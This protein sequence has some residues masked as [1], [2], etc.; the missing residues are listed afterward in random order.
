M[1]TGS[2][3]AAARRQLSAVEGESP[4]DGVLITDGA[5]RRYLSGFT[6]SAGI[7]LITASAALLLT[8]S[9]YIEQATAQA[10]EFEVIKYEGPP[11]PT[12]AAQAKR[13]SAHRLGFESEEMSVDSYRRLLQA[14]EREAAEVELVPLRGFVEQLRQVKDAGEIELIRQAVEIADR[15]FEQV[16][17]GLRPGTTEREVAW[18]LEVAMRQRGADGLSF[19]IIVAAGPNGAMPHHSPSDRPIQAGEPVVIDMG[20]RY[21]GYCSDMTRTIVLGEAGEQFWHV[22]QTVLQA[23]QACEAG[24]RAGLLGKQADALARDVI[25]AAGHKEH[26]GHGTGHGVGLEIHEAPYLTFTERGEATLP[27][28][29]VVTVE[30][31]IYLSGWGGVRIEDMIVVGQARSQI[32]TTAHKQPIIDLAS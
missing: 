29:C 13:L 14:L 4:L 22:Y 19:P 15:A 20:C 27:E 2:R 3:L 8:D 21:R 17:A 10:R 28:R 25:A 7:L 1:A 32:L 12:V 9:R 31:G 23:Q 24:V 30:P 6:G 26:F 11:W 5:N 16:A 18:L